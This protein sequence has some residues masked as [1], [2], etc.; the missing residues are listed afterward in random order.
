MAQEDAETDSRGRAVMEGICSGRLPERTHRDGASAKSRIVT[1]APFSKADSL[2]S[3]LR[4]L[5]FGSLKTTLCS[6]H[7]HHTHVKAAHLIW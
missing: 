6:Q 7:Y 3:M 5:T 4:R 1:S 2:L